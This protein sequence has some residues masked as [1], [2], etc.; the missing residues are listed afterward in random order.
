MHPLHFPDPSSYSS[1]PSEKL[2]SPFSIT[3]PANIWQ[4]AHELR[5]QTS[6]SDDTSCASSIGIIFRIT[7]GDLISGETGSSSQDSFLSSAL[8][9]TTDLDPATW[10]V[11]QEPGNASQANAITLSVYRDTTSGYDYTKGYHHL[12]DY[13]QNWCARF[14]NNLKHVLTFL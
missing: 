5:P 13:L 10:L 12:M 8:S 7:H 14:P 6:E 11:P 9:T 1:S 4:P 2:A 3:L